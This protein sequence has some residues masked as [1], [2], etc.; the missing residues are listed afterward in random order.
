[1]AGRGGEGGERM[2]LWDWGWGMGAGGGWGRGGCGSVG[3][4]RVRWG[5][6]VGAIVGLEALAEWGVGGG[7]E[8]GVKGVCSCK[9]LSE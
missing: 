6:V 5:G 4:G 2:G 1:M 9:C 3:W 8:G 7:G